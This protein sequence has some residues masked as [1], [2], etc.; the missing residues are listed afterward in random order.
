MKRTCGLAVLIGLGAFAVSQASATL[1]VNGDFEAGNTGFTSQY[2]YD[3]AGGGLASG[4]GTVSPEAAGSGKYAVGTSPQFFHSSFASFADHT[5]GI[6]N[7]NMMVVNGSVVQGRT[8]WSGSVL[9]PLV[10]GN[11]YTFSAWAA[12]VFAQNAPSLQFSFGGNILGT[13]TPN[14]GTGNWTQFT[15]TFV[16]G[17]NQN[18][19]LIDLNVLAQ[20][21]DFAVD[22]ISLVAVPE[23]TTMI[24]GVL[25]LL[26]FGMSTLRILRKRTA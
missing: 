23:P 20:G 2:V 17:A 3:P 12:N 6:G 19:G 18:G 10:I 4:S 7:V 24:A 21:N 25:L 1:I 15:A 22:D 11:T 14:A 26:P 9:S 16:A 8:V 5:P 13:L